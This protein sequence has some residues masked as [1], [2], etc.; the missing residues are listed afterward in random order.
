MRPQGPVCWPCA[1]EIQAGLDAARRDKTLLDRLVDIRSAEADDPDGSITDPDYAEAFRDAG[2]DLAGLPPAEAGAKIKARPPSVAL[3]LAAALDDW[4]AIRRGSGETPAGAAQLSE[5]ARVADPDPW[6]NDLR[7]ALDQ[8]DKAARLAGLQALAK[9][10][11]FEELGAISLH[12][13]GTG[14]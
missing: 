10:A 11:K 12:L 6:R 3:A 5:A 7:T 8:S 13:L 2:I 4:A 9:T 14:L 1:R